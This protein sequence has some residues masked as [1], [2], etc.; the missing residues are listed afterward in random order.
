MKH[1]KFIAAVI[2][3]GAV[4][5]ATGAIAK[6]GHGGKGGFGAGM[7]FEQIDAD[8][9]GQISKQEM[10]GL[11]EARFAATDADGDG[12]LNE[13]ERKA[14]WKEIR[15]RHNCGNGNNRKT[16]NETGSR[17]GKGNRGKGKPRGRSGP[18]RSGNA[19]GGRPAPTGAQ[20]ARQRKRNKPA[21]S[22][23]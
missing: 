5:G 2:V 17:Q 12:K 4:V 7:T 16:G 1:T 8:G 21:R 18:P 19:E 9:N 13:E 20:K 23:A 11:R 14:L 15:N 6:P 22:A 10:E 3:A